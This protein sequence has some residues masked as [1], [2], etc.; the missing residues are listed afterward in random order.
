LTGS[1]ARA[2][3]DHNNTPKNTDD[4]FNAFIEAPLEL[5]QASGR[6]EAGIMR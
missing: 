6:M 5:Q 4:A 3:P 2:A 1:C